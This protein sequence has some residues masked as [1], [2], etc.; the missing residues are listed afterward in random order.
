MYTYEM[1]T[2]QIAELKREYGISVFYFGDSVM[3]RPLPCLVI[4]GNRK[5]LFVN[6]SHHGLEFITSQVLMNFAAEVLARGSYV[7]A[8]MY[9]APMINPDGV[10][11]AQ[12]AIN[13]ATFDYKR[14]VYLNGESTDFS[15]GWQSNIRGVDLNH[16]YPAL[17]GTGALASFA[18]G[19]T[20]PGRTRYS[21]MYPFSEP[22]S[23]AVRDLCFE[24]DFDMAIALHSQGEVIY[25]NFNNLADERA[26][27]I[28][29]RLA[30]AS[31]YALEEAEGIASTGGFKDWFMQ[32]YR[33][34]AYTVE[35]G[36]G[37]NPLPQ[38]QLPQIQK[39]VFPLLYEAARLA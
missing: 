4:P 27:Q 7:G 5:K 20:C 17:W 6:A 10:N 29:Q 19:Y 3:G 21:G 16:N 37:K 23:R 38:E 24:R 22:E 9:L 18:A 32:E 31:G 34:P 1:L 15:S 26:K 25:W 35:V 2:E 13:P 33:R 8:T 11:L 14:A 39:D 12:N 28:G 36:R 30:A